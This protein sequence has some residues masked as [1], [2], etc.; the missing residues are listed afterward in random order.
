MWNAWKGQ[1]LIQAE[2]KLF[3]SFDFGG[4]IKMFLKKKKQTQQWES[5]GKCLKMVAADILSDEKS[6][7]LV[8]SINTWKEGVFLVT[9]RKGQKN[10]GTL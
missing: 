9:T 6:C 4:V 5:S 7:C 1:I 2:N 10:E 3:K 8:Y